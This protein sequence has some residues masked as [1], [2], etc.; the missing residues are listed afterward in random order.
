MEM[1]SR[2]RETTGLA[3]AFGKGGGGGGGG[4]LL[5]GCTPIPSPAVSGAAPGAGPGVGSGDPP[6]QPPAGGRGGLRGHS[7][8]PPGLGGCGADRAPR[9]GRA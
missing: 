3:E 2:H 5:P 6:G 4:R 8:R 9:R 7:R 1:Y